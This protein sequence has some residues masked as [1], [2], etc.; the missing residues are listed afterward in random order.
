MTIKSSN[1]MGNL[2]AQDMDINTPSFGLLVGL[3]VVLV[4]LGWVDWVAGWYVLQD[5][6]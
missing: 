3:K 1:G 4:G 5:E 2:V 6:I